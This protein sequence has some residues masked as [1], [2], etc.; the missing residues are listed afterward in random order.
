MPLPIAGQV[1]PSAAWSGDGS[2]IEFRQDKTGSIV[3]SEF[4][5]RYAEA[6][7]RGQLFFAA[8]QAATAVTNLATTATGFILSNPAGSGKNLWIVDICVQQAVAA[9]AAI[10]S[11]VLAAN[12]NPVAA[13]TVHTTPLTVRASLLGSAN[14]AAGLADSAATLPVAPVVIR[15][16]YAPSISATA[17]TS[18]A[19]YVKDE[20]AGAIG[21]APG[22]T[23]SLSATTAI[24]VFASMTWLELPI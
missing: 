16:L 2:N 17:T 11:V 19:P 3:A 8:V 18:T 12:V 10:D 22:C 14:A 23:I 21:I 5:P 6:A 9:A 13:T 24:S 4:L 1:G 7:Y 20:V 15:S